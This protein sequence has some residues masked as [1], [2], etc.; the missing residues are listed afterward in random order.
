MLCQHCQQRE[1]KVRLIKTIKGQT[2]ELNLCEPCSQK[3]H[4]FN[5]FIQPGIVVPDFLQALFGFMSQPEKSGIP[6]EESCPRC[7]ITFNQITRAGKLGCSVCYDKFEPQLES[8][9]RRIHGGGQHV[10]KIPLRR[11]AAIKDK[12]QLQNLKEQLAG[13]IQQEKFEEAAVIRDQI[14]QMDQKQRGE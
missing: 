5:I 9:L 1:A 3:I 11:G 12:M 13:L 14:K 2:E 8:L 7:G 10:G 4:E 6:Q